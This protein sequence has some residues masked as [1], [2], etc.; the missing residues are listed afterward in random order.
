MS[1]LGPQQQNQSYSGLLQIPGG[2]TAQL[3]TVQ[4]GDGNPTGLQISSAG[5]N[6]ATASTF[7]AT[8]NGVAIPGVLPRLISDGFGDYV[9]VID[10]GADSTGVTNSAVAFFNAA[11]AA[12]IVFVP[13][14]VYKLD[15]TPA[16]SATWM[17]LGDVTFTGAGSLNGSKISFDDVISIYRN[18]F[19]EGVTIRGDITG[20]NTFMRA[21]NDRTNFYSTTGGAYTSYDTLAQIGNGVSDPYYNHSYGYEARQTFRGTSGIA[22]FYGF[23]SG[24]TVNGSAGSALAAAV[25]C[26]GFMCG[27]AQGTGTIYNQSA[28]YCN[29]LT[30]GIS[31][32]GIS[33]GVTAGTNKYNVYAIGD[34]ENLFQGPVTLNGAVALNAGGSLGSGEKIALTGQSGFTFASDINLIFQGNA[35]TATIVSLN[36]DGN[37]YEPLTLA[38]EIVVSTAPLRL[39]VLTVSTLPLAASAGAAR[40]FVSDSNVVAAGNFGAVVAGGGANTVPVYS[41]GTNWRIG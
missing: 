5:T 39:P 27:D 29:D 14:G 12:S 15:T 13:S 34:A 35:S 31:N 16:N 6:A 4:D 10:F 36:D 19:V 23:Y 38:A 3:Q 37:T 28:F 17:L 40:A 18:V 24:L 11:A 33:L 1:N 21:Y 7:I 2:V 32:Y 9:S 30:R 20:S 26:F 22:N 8:D 41:D 25:N